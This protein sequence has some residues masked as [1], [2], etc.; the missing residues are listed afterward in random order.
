VNPLSHYPIIP[1]YKHKEKKDS[2]T[3][4][5][6]NLPAKSN[7]K[8]KT[9]NFKNAVLY[10]CSFPFYLSQYSTVKAKAQPENRFHT[11]G[12]KKKVV[13]KEKEKE[14]NNWLTTNSK[15]VV[16]GSPLLLEIDT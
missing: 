14:K 9:P 11:R 12:Q 3:L 8:E 6:E 13:E 2:C 7:A 15:K 10:D 16:A 5:I 4:T 1:P